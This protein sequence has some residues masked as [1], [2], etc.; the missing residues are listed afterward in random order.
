MDIIKLRDKW[1]RMPTGLR[2]TVITNAIAWLESDERPQVKP[3]H[4][5]FLID[6]E[7]QLQ[8]LLNQ[9]RLSE[10][11]FVQTAQTYGSFP[12]FDKFVRKNL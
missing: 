11:W 5:S 1:V 3:E 7:N 10:Q 8:Q 4:L 6:F 12:F 9:P 2:N